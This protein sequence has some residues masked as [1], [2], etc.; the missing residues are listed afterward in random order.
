MKRIAIVVVMVLMSMAAPARSVH[1]FTFSQ[2]SRTVSHLNSQKEMMIY[3]GY[4]YELPTYVLVNEVWMERINSA[5]YELWV[6]GYD[7][8]TGDEIYMPLDLQCVWLFSGNRMYNAAQYLRF[9]VN[10]VQPTFTWHI[11]AYN[12]FVRVV[13]RHGYSR[14]YHYDVHRYGWMPPAYTLGPGAPPP[15]IPHYYLRTPQQP[16]PMPSGT[17][18]PGVNRPSVPASAVEAT[19]DRDP[20][21]GTQVRSSHNTSATATSRSSST[22]TSGSN[23]SATTTGTS[24]STANT[25]PSRNTA[26]SRNTSSANTTTNSRSSAASGTAS[27]TRSSANSARN[28]S[29]TTTPADNSSSRGGSDNGNSLKRA[30]EASAAPTAP[31]AAP[32]TSRSSGN[33]NASTSRNSGSTTSRG[34]RTNT[35]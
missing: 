6:F 3:C 13:H 32:S 9:H 11:P 30:P 5:Y 21:T 14:T 22:A 31:S 27:P 24:R 4:D 1:Y 10:V 12:P 33:N 25:T 29:R 28:S 15:P 16:A 20:G 26:T 2:A 19:R 34:Q 23:R 17:W 7:A 35:R 18:T 8:Y